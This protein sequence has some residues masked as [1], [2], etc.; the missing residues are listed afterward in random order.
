[1]RRRHPLPRLW[2][3]TDERMG[4]AL[5]SSLEALPRGSG[6]V[7]RHYTLGKEARAAL[8][9]RILPSAKRRGLVLLVAGDP[10]PGADGVHGRNP[11]RRPG[12]IRSAPVHGMRELRRAIAA[13]VDLIFLSPVFPTRSHPG[14][15]ALGTM[16]FAALARRAPMPVTALG[17][18]TRTK[19]PRLDRL[20]AHGWAGIDGLTRRNQNLKAVPT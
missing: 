4:D 13:G 8:F 17:G 9:A 7:V 12:L 1:M 14:A 11:A 2:L 20:G 6:V 15:K 19:A 3:M 10:M 18:M 5:W 16:R